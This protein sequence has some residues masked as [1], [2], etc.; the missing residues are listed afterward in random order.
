[1]NQHN[2]IFKEYETGNEPTCTSEGNAIFECLGCGDTMKVPALH[3]F[4]YFVEHLDGQ[5]PTCT[6]Y[7]Y[8]TFECLYCTESETRFVPPTHSYDPV[9]KYPAT[10]T[11]GSITDYTCTVCGDCYREESEPNGHNKSFFPISSTVTCTEDGVEIYSCYNCSEL[12]VEEVEATGHNWEVDENTIDVTTH[13]A[14]AS[15][16]NDGCGQTTTVSTVGMEQDPI[17]TTVP[18][19]ISVTAGSDW[20][21]YTFEHQEG[22]LTITL[23]KDT[24][25]LM[26]K[27]TSGKYETQFFW[28]G[29]TEITAELMASGTYV[30]A[31]SSGSD[32]E[33]ELNITTAFEEK[34]LP[35]YGEA[36]SKPIV[37]ES[38]NT[39]YTSTGTTW[40]KYQTEYAGK[41]TITVT[42]TATVK[43][44]ENPEELTAYTAPFDDVYG[45]TVYYICVESTEEVTIK[46]GLEAPVGSMDNPFELA[47][48][49]NA[50][51]V[52]SYSQY[53]TKYTADKAGKLTV[54]YDSS[55]VINVGY[56]YNP[57]MLMGQFDNGK[58]IIDVVP[59]DVIYIG[60]NEASGSAVELTLAVSFEEASTEPTEEMGEKIGTLDVTVTETYGYTDEYTYTATNAGTYTFFVPANLGFYSKAQQD[61]F[62][63]AEADFYSNSIGTFVS[64]ELTAGQ[65]YT[66]YVGSTTAD[67]YTLDIYYA[68]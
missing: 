5:A 30:I 11:L 3:R 32:A 14:T 36:S 19:T 16:T 63:D 33:V 61:V 43:Y 8:S 25:Y 46:V 56:G 34:D 60:F 18:S 48:G 17:A 31:V 47:S 10:C 64:V 50:I 24:Y 54:S 40:F 35:D 22:I 65:S 53:Y 67:T 59:N 44:G 55:I 4:T 49:D 58:A 28:G 57:Y 13:T 29:E 23:D 12:V 2:W 41:V 66:F 20:V 37:I 15:C 42:G 51:T 62:G 45:Y 6:A 68:E 26:V 38:T 9:Q 1:S 52:P 27:D 21:Y 39:E 7:G